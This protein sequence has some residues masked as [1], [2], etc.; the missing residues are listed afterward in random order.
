MILRFASGLKSFACFLYRAASSSDYQLNFNGLV[1]PIAPAHI[2]SILGSSIH[3][4]T[5]KPEPTYESTPLIVFAA[6]YEG[7]K[8]LWHEDDPTNPVNAY[9]ES[10]VAAERHLQENYPNHAILR[11]SIIYGP[12][13]PLMPVGRSLP[14]AVSPAMDSFQLLLALHSVLSLP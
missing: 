14:L 13:A 9:G 7:N 5:R 2:R 4:L 3:L 10:K 12:Q 8:S 11:S 6:A 1:H